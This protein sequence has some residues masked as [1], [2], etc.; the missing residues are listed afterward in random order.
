MPEQ[1]QKS[2]IQ[3]STLQQNQIDLFQADELI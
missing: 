3:G 2:G 1:Q